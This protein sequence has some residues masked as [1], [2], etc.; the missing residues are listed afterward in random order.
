MSQDIVADG[1]NQI[2]NAKMV[3]KRKLKI[4]R[5][6]K[7]LINVLEMMKQK[8]HINYSL[9]EEEKILEIE[10]LKLNVCRAVKPRYYAKHADVDKYLRRFLP[11]RNFGVLVVSTNRGL[12]GHQEAL[13]TKTGGSILAYFY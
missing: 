11:S 12:I 13:D 6:S 4:K 3:E 10:I 2:M 9:N 5:Y 7:V 8:G 1:L